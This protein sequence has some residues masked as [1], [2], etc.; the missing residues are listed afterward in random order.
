MR[1]GIIYGKRFGKYQ[2]FNEK[3]L[4]GNSIDMKFDVIYNSMVLHLRL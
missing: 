2:E 1:R 3:P 4:S